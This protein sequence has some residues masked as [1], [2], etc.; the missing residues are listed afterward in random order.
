MKKLPYGI[1]NYE[2]LIEDGYYYVDKTEYIERLEN[3]AEKRIMFLRP[4]K[5]GKTLFTS[6]LENYYDIKKEDKFEKLYK[7]TYIGKN[8]TKL[9]NKYHILRFN[10]SGIDT[11]TEKSTIKGFKNEVASSIEV[12]SKRYEIDFYTNQEDEAENILN[13]LLKAFYIQKSQE[14]IYV[15]IDEYDHFANELLGFNTDKFKELVSK[16]GKIRKWYEVL[17]E[18]TETVVDRIF[19]TG[20]APVTLDSLTSGFNICSDKTRDRNFNE[21]LGFTKEEL[22]ELMKSQNIA[23]EEQENLLL[24]MKENYDGYIFALKAKEKMYNSNMCLYFLNEYTTYKEI[25][26]QL[27]DVNIASDYSKIG[28][29]LNLCKGENREEIIK[30]TVSGEGI[31]TEI[32]E[33]FNPSMEFGETELVSM[34]FYLGYLT[35]AGERLG[36]AEL[37]IPNNVMKEIYSDYFLK[38]IDQQAQMTIELKEYNEILEEMALEGRIDKIVEMLEKYLKNL[39]NRDFQRFDEKYVKLIFYSIAMNLKIYSVKS[40]LEVER[41]YPDILLIPRDRTKGY[42]A[43]MIEFKYLKKG[44]E[45]QLEKSQREAREQIEKYSNKQEMKDIEKMNKYTIVVVN[46]KTYVEKID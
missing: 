35:I 5:F 7:D 13:N 22:E 37:K 27:V 19:I 28:K 3:L 34:L 9:K 29:M 12:F 46:D 42:N 31:L 18:G 24:I 11:S 38:M 44:E 16:S 23:K 33:K 36:R 14:K 6:M 4:R 10:F 32:V 17:K 8:P 26:D 15:I 40:E 2:E 41:E 45:K 1:S 21:M 39:S 43:I 20:V 30:K 25:P